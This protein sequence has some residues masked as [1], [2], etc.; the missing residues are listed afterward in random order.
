MKTTINGT[1]LWS[2][3]EIATSDMHAL[4]EFNI[5]VGSIK[6]FYNKYMRLKNELNHEK[7]KSAALEEKIKTQNRFVVFA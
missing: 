1:Q 6:D 2:V 5:T 4:E 3:E 7:L